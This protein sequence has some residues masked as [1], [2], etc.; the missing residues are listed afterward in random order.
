VSRY[1]WKGSIE[2]SE[3]WLVLLKTRLELGPKVTK[4]VVGLH[5]YETPEVISLEISSGSAHYLDWVT[6]SVIAEQDW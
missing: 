3:E 1:W 6:D 5:P 2:Q 4:A